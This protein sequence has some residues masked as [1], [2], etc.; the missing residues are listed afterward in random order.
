MKTP[1]RIPARRSLAELGELYRHAE[2]AQAA[3]AID[4]MDAE[5]RPLASETALL[6]ARIHLRQRNP[7]AALDDVARNA[8]RFTTG[9]AR[10][11]AAVLSGAAYTR[12]GDERAAAAQYKR[13]AA[14][15]P[16]DERLAH[17]LRYQR[18]LGAW[19][20]RK[21]DLAEK[22]LDELEAL[23][24]SDDLLLEARVLRG[25]VAASRER[26]PEQGAILLDALRLMRAMPD[27]PALAHATIAS[28]IA[29][30]AREMPSAAL[31]DAAY[32]EHSAVPWTADLGELHFTM[33]RAVGWRH[34]LDG[35]YFNAFRRLKDA[36]AAAPS[37][38]W[39]VMASCDRAYFATVLGERRWA[40]QELSDAHELANS[41][42]WTTLDAEERFALPVLA[43]LF[44][45]RDPALALSYVARYKDVGKRFA[46]TLASSDDRR[47][48]AMESYSFG[49]VQH[50]LGESDEA[51][52]LLREAWK[53][54]DR[55]GYDWRAGRAAAALAAATGDDGWKEKAAQK[56]R[57]YGR[58]WLVSSASTNALPAP[59]ELAA[60]TPAQ[61]AVYEQLLRG[62]ST[63]QIAAEQGR[64]EYTIRNHVKAI[65]KAFRVRSRPALIARAI[66]TSGPRVTGAE[67]P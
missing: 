27:P 66:G 20:A 53:I 11:E 3:A 32:A 58:S 22:L 5:N 24:P 8:A 6:R 41:V 28:Q 19:I 51:A 1:A 17:E 36:S 31:R 56:L 47:V 63:A 34:A 40:E 48:T 61:R 55:I 59:A 12:L 13:A 2:Y 30:L 49:M 45:P 35:D 37:D 64:S 16:D 21:L 10:A 50:A 26:L 43:E 42:V 38:A 33:L 57:P 60:L 15:A 23:E 54:Y 4:E 52:R 62:L 9:R 39:R 67:L 44:A 25:A 29:Y 18:A 7:A 65:F 46:R 14:L